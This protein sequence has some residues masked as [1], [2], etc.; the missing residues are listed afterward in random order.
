MSEA[1][2]VCREEP[3]IVNGQHGYSQR[4]PAGI[5]KLPAGEQIKRCL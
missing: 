1:L 2:K 5:L 4:K 3:V